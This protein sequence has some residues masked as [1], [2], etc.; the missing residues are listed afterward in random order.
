MPLVKGA[1]LRRQTAECARKVMWAA[2]AFDA[3]AASI[4]EYPPDGGG[5]GSAFPCLEMVETFRVMEIDWWGETTDLGGVWDWFRNGDQVGY[6]A[7]SKPEVSESHMRQLD[8]LID[9]GNLER[10]IFRRYGSIY[11]YVLEKQKNAYAL[12]MR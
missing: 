11:C 2:D 12:S 9:D 5:A 8:R 3:Y 7:I 6:I 1:V 4:G 10:G